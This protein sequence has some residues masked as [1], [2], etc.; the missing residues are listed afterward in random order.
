MKRCLVLAIV[1]MLAVVGSARASWVDTSLTHLILRADAPGSA[2]EFAAI[3]ERAGGHV[4][5]LYPPR[6]AVVF[7]SPQALAAPEVAPWIARA[8]V[9]AI[10]IASLG[11]VAED[12]AR[13]ARV[14]NLS[15]VMRAEEAAAPSHDELAEAARHQ[16]P[17]AGPV[18]VKLPDMPEF[19]DAPTHIPYGAQY[20]DTSMYLAGSTAVGVW[21]LEAAGATYDWSQAEED[22]TLAGVQT[23]LT[24]WTT[25][26]S[27]LA[28]LSFTVEIHT[29]VPVSGVPI[30]NPQS[31]DTVWIGEALAN[32]GW[33]GANA[34]E[35]CYAYNSSIR[36]TYQTNWCFSYFIVDSDPAVNQGL[37]SGGGYAWAYFG[38]P[39]VWMSRYSTWAYNWQNYYRAVPM[40][41]MGHIYYATDEYN[42]TQ[43]FSGYLNWSDNLNPNIVCLMNQNVHTAICMPSRR[44]C[45]IHDPDLNGVT[46]PLDVPPTA[47]LF[48]FLPDPTGDFTPTWSGRALVS[49][50]DNLNSH[51][52]HYSPPHDVTL[53]KIVAVE[54]RVDG[55]AWSA[56]TPLDGTFDAYGE[57]FQWTSPPLANGVHL[58]EARAQT[59]QGVWTT[60]FDSDEVT[61]TGSP[62]D[63]PV[64]A[65]LV[66]GLRVMPNPA[67]DAVELA[68]RVEQGPVALSIVDVGG[69]VVFS[70]PG[71]PGEG[72]F[73]WTG[74]DATGKPVA[75]GVYWVRLS[76]RDGERTR[77]LVWMR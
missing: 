75:A 64:V 33:A 31:W 39:W 58:A 35:R 74:R 56:A 67:R 4:A 48:T 27:T 18:P 52:A 61:V 68:W 20:Y 29:D 40:H 77:R 19:R 70:R 44:Q 43:E 66:D 28:F 72:S 30:E 59:S 57:D 54:C 36:N 65:G 55:G 41:E 76:A 10:D 53:G 2:T 71:A 25:F 32:A 49:T 6:T 63:A 50:L 23:A 17:D 21:L 26:G 51:D 34:F 9:G 69:R 62:V 13:S 1:V 47:D 46:A 8:D 60:T 38:G 73:Q 15:L 22:Q 45:A 42:G 3:L 16:L 37:F 11:P 12:V 5:V 14:W 7:A 24:D